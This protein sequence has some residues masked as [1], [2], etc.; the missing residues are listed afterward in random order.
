MPRLDVGAARREYAKIRDTF[1]KLGQTR[2]RYSRKGMDTATLDGQLHDLL[3][4]A[5]VLVDVAMAAKCEARGVHTTFPRLART[6][7]KYDSL[8]GLRRAHRRLCDR[9]RRPCGREG[10]EAQDAE[11]LRQAWDLLQSDAEV[12]PCPVKRIVLT[13]LSVD[14]DSIGSTRS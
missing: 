8:A 6:H 7:P 1:R 5:R 3:N 2:S 4:Q 11:I 10:L 13:P 14:V 12:T 9:R